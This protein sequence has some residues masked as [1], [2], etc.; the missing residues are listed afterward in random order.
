MK[1]R[2]ESNKTAKDLIETYGL[3]KTVYIYSETEV[4]EIISKVLED[5]AESAETSCHCVEGFCNGVDKS[6]ITKV[7]I[8]KYLK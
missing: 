2:E 8:E 4:R 3:N 7:D 1:T 6:S 5:A